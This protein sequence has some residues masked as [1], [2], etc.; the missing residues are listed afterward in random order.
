MKKTFIICLLFIAFCLLFIPSVRADY[1]LPYPSYMPGN[2]MYHVMRIIDQLKR[3]WYWGNIAQVKYHQGLGDKYLV[4]AKTLFEYKQYLLA[5]DA[6][7]RSDSQVA[8]IM[9][10][11]DK[12]RQQGIDP[13]LLITSVAEEM[14]VHLSVLEVMKTQLPKE[15]V[16][17]PEKAKATDLQIG[18][19]LE[20]SFAL[21]EKIYVEATSSAQSDPV[22]TIQQ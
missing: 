4:E 21:R 14:S 18:T 17:T 15:F 12:A 20:N 2:K 7:A 19:M 11:I 8:V 16:W 1:V 10:F 3:Y 5:T 6:L 13:K 9:P 22:H